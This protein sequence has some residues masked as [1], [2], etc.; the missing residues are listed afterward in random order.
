MSFHIE[1]DWCGAD[2]YGKSYAVLKVTIVGRPSRSLLDR[3]EV[4]PSLHFCVEPTR[5]S[6]DDLDRMGLDDETADGG[7]YASALKFIQ[8]RATEPPDMGMEWRLLQTG[9]PLTDRSDRSD[10]GQALPVAVEGLRAVDDEFCHRAF[11]ERCKPGGIIA[12]RMSKIPVVIPERAWNA[13]FA[14]EII[15]VDQL[16]AVPDEQL[17]QLSGVGVTSLARIREA[18]DAYRQLAPP[19]SIEV[20]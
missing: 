16:E 3:D 5:L 8:G 4:R 1:C 12:L 20:K 19:D 17:L 11:H 6:A 10:H 15:T 7:C 13:I 14:T 18:I 2:L 9:A